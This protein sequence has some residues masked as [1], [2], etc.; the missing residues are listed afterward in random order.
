MYILLCFAFFLVMII[1]MDFLEDREE[2]LPTS[3][4]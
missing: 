1:S 2:D 3:K 4:Q